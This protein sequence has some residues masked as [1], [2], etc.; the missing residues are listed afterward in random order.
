MVTIPR[1]RTLD[2]SLALLREGYTFIGSRCQR[3]DSD[4]FRTRLMGQQAFC[5]QGAEAAEVFFT[6]GRFTRKVAL[7]PTTLRLLQDLGSVNQ[8]DGEAHLSRKQMFLSLMRPAESQRLAT[9]LTDHWSARIS[10]WEKMEQVVLFDEVQ[11]LLCRAVCAWAGIPLSEQSSQKRTQEFAAMLDGAGAAGSRMVRGLLLRNRCERWAQRVIERI[12]DGSRDAPPESAAYAV[13]WHREPDGSL[14]DP[15]V[16]AVELI[17]VLRPTVAI[18]YFVTFASMALHEHPA[19]VER[20]RAGGAHELEWFVQEVRRASPLFAL[21]AGR[22]RQPFDWQGHHFAIGTWMILDLY[23]TNH[24]PRI[25][26]DPG[27]FRP[28]RFRDWNGNPFTFIPQGGGDH[29]T[30]HR[31]PG[32]WATIDVLKGATRLLT[33]AMRYDVPAQNMHVDLSRMPTLPQSRFVISNVQRVA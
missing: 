13:A 25:W 18:A 27:V 30:G 5:L 19:W 22:V 4:I 15:V 3:L 32:E 7:P 6:P 23:G 2:S 16:A 17:N 31:C 10:T 29:A 14:L 8:L 26:G 11:A 1:E 9:V 24:D 20:L 28:E 33:R 21:T 12:R